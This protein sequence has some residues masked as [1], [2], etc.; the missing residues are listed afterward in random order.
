MIWRIKWATPNLEIQ[1]HAYNN[2]IHCPRNNKKNV[3]CRVPC[4]IWPRWTNCA[5]AVLRIF[6]SHLI[7]FQVAR[8]I[9]QQICVEEDIKELWSPCSTHSNNRFSILQFCSFSVIREILWYQMNLMP[10]GPS[11]KWL[12]DY[13]GS[14]LESLMIM[15]H[16]WDP[17]KNDKDSNYCT[18]LSLSKEVLSYHPVRFK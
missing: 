17:S 5:E 4:N 10:M 7:S 9:L 3:T 16:S 2:I 6:L 14:M 8:L 11:L 1:I 15:E 13:W 12:F 18:I